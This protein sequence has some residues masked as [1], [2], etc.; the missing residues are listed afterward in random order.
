M[1]F[2]PTEIDLGHNNIESEGRVKTI[3]KIFIGLGV[4]AGV[5]I[6]G[7]I[8][9]IFLAVRSLDDPLAE[10][11]VTSKI[12]PLMKSWDPD[13]MVLLF[14]EKYGI[15]WATDMRLGIL[16]STKMN[17]SQLDL[18]ELFNRCKSELGK[19]QKFKDPNC[20]RDKKDP[21][22]FSSCLMTATFE[23]GDAVVNILLSQQ[24]S[25]GSYKIVG[26]VVVRSN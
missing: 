18:T 11:F 20:S 2:W 6:I 9:F 19:F 24:N 12:P 7:F 14:G 10:K 4:L 1:S 25:Q 26:F 23:K 21:N 16:E 22:S 13:Q 8:L 3:V 15:V 17:S 5:A